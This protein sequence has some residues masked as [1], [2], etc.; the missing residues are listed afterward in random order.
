MHF[1]L[2]AQ[3]TAGRIDTLQI[4]ILHLFH[5]PVALR[6]H[7][8]TALLNAIFMCPM[9][10]KNIFCSFSASMYSLNIY[11]HTQKH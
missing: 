9:G 4:S 2:F 1:K 3:L 7:G 10:E 8:K 11:T 5:L 6:I